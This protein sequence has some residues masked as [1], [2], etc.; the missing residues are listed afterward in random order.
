MASHRDDDVLQRAVELSPGDLVAIVQ[1]LANGHTQATAEMA[2]GMESAKIRRAE[3]SSA[4][5]CDCQGVSERKGD[6][7]AGG[8]REVFRVG[9]PLDGG[10][11]DD[12]HFGGEWRVGGAQNT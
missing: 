4:H 11:Q 10:I 3:I 5:E 2:A 7:S 9:F 8:G 12:I 1:D 6:G